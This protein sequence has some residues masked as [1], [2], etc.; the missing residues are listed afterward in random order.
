[1]KRIYMVYIVV[2]LFLGSGLFLEIGQVGSCAAAVEISIPNNVAG[3]SG[4]FIKVPVNISNVTGMGVLSV[5][6]KVVYD[7]SLLTAT[8]ASTA[9][10]IS[11]PWGVPTYFVTPGQITIGMASFTPPASS[12]TLLYIRFK[13]SDTATVDSKSNVKFNLAELN[14]GAV[15]GTT[16]DGLFTVIGNHAPVAVNDSYNTNEDTVLNVSSPGVSAMTLM[17]MGTHLKR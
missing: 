1:M 8:D 14:E 3:E 10:T 16:T 4:N 9:G 15:P 2:L 6:L 13:V 12:G 5:W 11:E 7:N 17:L